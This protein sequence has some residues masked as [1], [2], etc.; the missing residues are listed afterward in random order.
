[1]TATSPSRRA[2]LID[3]GGVLM[4]D[5]LTAA[6]TFWGGRLGIPPHAF[7][8]AVFAGSDDHVLIGRTSEVAWW[9]IIADRLHVGEDV[10][11]AIRHDLTVRQT[12]DTDL[13]TGLRRVRDRAT[14]AI[15]SNAWPDMRESIADAGW[16]FADAII[17]SC[18][19]GYAKPDV[20]IYETA[21]HSIGVDAGDALFIDDTPGHVETA[22]SLG[23]TGH[24]HTH[25]GE[26][27]DRIEHFV[28][29][30]GPGGPPT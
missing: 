11:A 23:M 17:L 26:T 25:T 8:A 10:V 9:R 15:V 22:R 1:M 29:S 5:D 19:V 14:I 27:L 18:D 12:W 30:Q 28:Q 16:D 4:P 6:A 21:L 2:V 7:L 13:L 3:V 20:R 24:I